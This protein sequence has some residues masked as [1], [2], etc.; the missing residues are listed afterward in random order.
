M[1]P[2]DV[3]VLT[4]VYRS[5]ITVDRAIRSA[6][7]QPVSVEVMCVD[8]YPLHP[9]VQQVYDPRVKWIVHEKNGGPG[10][11]LE[12]AACAA[13]G[14]YC[15]MLGDDDYLEPNCLDKLVKV[16]DDN[17]ALA[18]AYGT[19]K[20]WGERS[21]EFRPNPFTKE[22]FYFHH[23][24]LNGYLWRRSLKEQHGLKYR[25]EIEVNGRWLGIQD[26]E[27]ILQL[28][29]HGDGICLPD[30][31]VLNYLLRKGR[32]ADAVAE[33]KRKV[34]MSAMMRHPELK[35]EAMYAL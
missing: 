1:N 28:L 23:A 33:H 16:L 32:N 25:D 20:F 34:M 3:S 29:H 24:S 4:P 2:P 12:T 5:G 9:T 27:L 13:T 11:A 7:S 10:A 15:I 21:D 30:V 19:T 6:L 18:F 35:D 22:E 14:R 26:W 31:R 17:P 8:D